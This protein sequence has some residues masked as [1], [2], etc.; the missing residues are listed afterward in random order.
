[1]AV[2][3]KKKAS[4]TA[5]VKPQASVERQSLY[6][7]HGDDDFLVTEEAR[8]IIATL[9]PKGASE[10]ALETV[11]GAAANQAEAA[12]IFARLF[13]ALQSRSFFAT[14]KVV[15]WRDTNLLGKNTTA[16]AAAVAGETGFLAALND[17]LQTGLPPGTSLVVTAT[18][19]DGRRTIAKTFARAGKVISFEADPYKP[20]KD[21]AQA[22]E[23][24]RR[25]AT[26]FGKGLAED[27]ALLVVELAA[28][29]R[30]TIR[31]EL[32]KAAAYVGTADAIREED[33]RVIGSWRPGG[34]VWDLPD[35]LGQRDLSRALRVLDGL[36]F[37]GEKPPGLIFGLI[38]RVRLLLVLNVLAEKKALRLGGDYPSF[39]SQ[40][41]RLPPWVL[42]NL[43]TDKKLNPLGAHP[44]IIF[45]AV[46]GA[47]RY[48]LAELQNAM[49]I[50]LEAN[51]RLFSSGGTPRAILEEALINICRK[52]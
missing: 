4:A 29:D 35:A 34:V 43:S 20:E 32:E 48:T 15:W 18:D 2:T 1:M 46:A 21:R 27:A 40:M 12:Q 5:V 23:F 19:L 36:L 50:L 42:E 3:Q 17:L 39:K 26:E 30:R 38:S 16:A 47:A 6:V 49:E 45:K 24:A 9:T 22:L 51:E 44:Y 31:S 7:I 33:L 41:E 13:E 28:G 52:A 14:E 8:R 11:D 25:T 10:F 37:M